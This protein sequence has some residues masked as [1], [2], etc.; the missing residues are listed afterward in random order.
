MNNKKALQNFHLQGF[1]FSGD[2]AGITTLSLVC[3]EMYINT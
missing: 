1:L 3:T 2:P